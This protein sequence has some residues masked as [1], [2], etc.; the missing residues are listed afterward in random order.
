MYIQC[1][2]L[3]IQLSDEKDIIG[4]KVDKIKMIDKSGFSEENFKY[5]DSKLDEIDM[6]VGEEKFRSA[7]EELDYLFEYVYKLKGIWK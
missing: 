5:I 6:L 4:G 2:F 1:Y 7:N 3:S